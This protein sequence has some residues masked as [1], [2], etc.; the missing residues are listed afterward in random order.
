MKLINAGKVLRWVRYRPQPP[1]HRALA[2]RQDGKPAAQPLLA[3]RERV[4]PRMDPWCRPLCEQ[5]A[6]GGGSSDDDEEEE[7]QPSGVPWPN[8][9]LPLLDKPARPASDGEKRALQRARVARIDMPAA[10][11]TDFSEM[12]PDFTMLEEHESKVQRLA[13]RLDDG[14]VAVPIDK[15]VHSVMSCTAGAGS[16]DYHE[17]RQR[18]RQERG[19]LGAAHA[20][21]M[22]AKVKEQW[23]AEQ[24][25]RA[26][27]QQQKTNK[28]A[29]KRQRQ[30]AAKQAPTVAADNPEPSVLPDGD[31]T[32]ADGAAAP[33]AAHAHR[34]RHMPTAEGTWEVH[35]LAASGDWVLGLGMR[36]SADTV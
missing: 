17:Y 5:E 31:A 36:H 20:E 13:G 22:K 3:A 11:R 23:E 34:R 35:H 33:K 24:G 29:A 32:R 26:A 4:E 14:Q 19:R 8:G 12:R 2:R 16:Q 21:A 15:D 10:A 9:R 27:E 7:A 28:R 25:E 1:P 30:K 18:R 6:E